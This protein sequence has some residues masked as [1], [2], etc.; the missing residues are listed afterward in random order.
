MLMDGPRMPREILVD[1]EQKLFYATPE[2]TAAMP[3]VHEKFKFVDDVLMEY[4][5]L[6]TH[7]MYDSTH[8]LRN[9][10]G[11]EVSY[12]VLPGSGSEA[13][14]MWAPFSDTAPNSNEAQL[15]PFLDRADHDILDDPDT[16]SWNQITKSMVMSA[17]LK[18]A[19][20]DMPVITIFSPVSDKAIGRDRLGMVSAGNNVLKEVI[21]DAQD[22]L[23]GPSSETQID[24]LH[25]HGASIGANRVLG[26]QNAYHVLAAACGSPK[27]R[28]SFLLLRK[29]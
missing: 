15:L 2:V 24:S 20:V 7:A 4:P 16:N 23:H 17:L 28:I 1:P 19:G 29:N 11:A 5:L 9:S 27:G 6:M 12:S 8:T 13:M 18:E 22:K 3:D 25:L 10:N 21:A 26:A 14:V